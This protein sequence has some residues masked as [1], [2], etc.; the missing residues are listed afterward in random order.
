M[1]KQV[2]KLNSPFAPNGV[3]HPKPVKGEDFYLSAEI[4]DKVTKTGDGPHDFIVEKVVTYTK[5]PIQEVIDADAQSVGVENVI[6]QFMKTGDPTLLPRDDGK[7]SA[8][9]VG[10]PESLME[11]KQLGDK[12]QLD[13]KKLPKELVKKMDMKS[14]V[15]NMDQ[16]QF[17]AFVKAVADR[18]SKKKEEVK[19]DGK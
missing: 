11:I 8:D 17:N 5:Q 14:F 1:E 16:E 10:A 19:E 13:F 3:K 15:E 12:A 2:L 7:H 4:L 18:S 6:R 9:Y